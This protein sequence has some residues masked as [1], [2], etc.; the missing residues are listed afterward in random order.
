MQSWYGTGIF[1]P[2]LGFNANN[3]IVAVLKPP[4]QMAFACRQD[5]RDEAPCRMISVPLFEDAL[6]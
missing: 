4:R 1:R 3:V 2:T 5:F 6:R